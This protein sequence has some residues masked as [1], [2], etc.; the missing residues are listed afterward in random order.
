MAQEQ[1]SFLDRLKTYFLPRTKQSI[2]RETGLLSEESTLFNTL[3]KKVFFDAYPGD[4]VVPLSSKASVN[5]H[6]VVK[7]NVIKE[8][9][10]K[11]G[12]TS[13]FGLPNRLR[14]DERGGSIRKPTLKELLQDLIGWNEDHD[15]LLF[16]MPFAALF[17]IA[18]FCL[19]TPVSLLKVITEV[20]PD[21]LNSVTGVGIHALASKIERWSGIK[22]GLGI[23]AG[24]IAFPVLSLVYAVSKLWAGVG[25]LITSPIKA[26]SMAY[27]LGKS[28]GGVP[29]IILGNVFRG[30]SYLASIVLY[31]PAVVFL[32]P[33]A[34][35]GLG[36]LLPMSMHAALS[37]GL[38]FAYLGVKGWLT[39]TSAMAF[40]ASFAPQTA[41]VLSTGILTAAAA[42][43]VRILEEVGEKLGSYFTPRDPHRINIIHYGSPERQHPI[44]HYAR[45]TY[46]RST[47]TTYNSLSRE[48]P[49]ERCSTTGPTTS[50]RARSSNKVTSNTIYQTRKTSTPKK[51]NPFI[52][53]AQREEATNSRV[54]VIVPENRAGSVD[55][56]AKVKDRITIVPPREEND[57][58]LYA[59]KDI[60]D[61]IISM[62][63]GAK[64]LYPP[65]NPKKMEL[66]T[67]QNMYEN[68]I[69]EAKSA[70]GGFFRGL[71]QIYHSDKNGLKNSDTES[72]SIMSTL[73]SLKDPVAKYFDDGLQEK[74]LEAVRKVFSTLQKEY[75]SEHI[76]SGLEE[77]KDLLIKINALLEG[78]IGKAEDHIAKMKVEIEVLGQGF[79]EIGEKL[80][81]IG[82]KTEELKINTEE[83]KINTEELKVNTEEL[84]INTEELKINTEELKINTE[85]LK[86]NTEELKINTEELKINTE[87]LRKK[88]EKSGENLAKAIVR[89]EKLEQGRNKLKNQEVESENQEKTLVF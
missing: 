85:E 12:L 63:Q 54:L 43:G 74:D 57:P 19:T 87:E 60:E 31:M 40:G 23:A 66:E 89:I 53:P 37:E 30:V 2:Y 55:S 13:F 56:E 1:Q 65:Y 9:D 59:I 5:G 86:I 83:L 25:M 50:H 80:E 71:A 41:S 34:F 42:T 14:E 68:E 76:V 10:L 45:P 58:M 52:A 46:T 39:T 22:Q 73:N 7:R 15:F 33:V 88:Q 78:Y 38:L 6:K 4:G 51:R 28:A 35:Q 27:A 84:K 11:S 24:V 62:L 67:Y 8:Y 29:G 47:N 32:G 49:I 79:K 61:N 21:L 18:R 69:R 36:A 48:H 3:F 26:A 70:F 82:K 17:N 75:N 16:L 77:Q 20:I 44:R 81:G 72:N 64:Q